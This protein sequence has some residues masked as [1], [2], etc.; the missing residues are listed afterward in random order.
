[1]SRMPIFLLLG[2][3][4][5]SSNAPSAEPSVDA[6]MDS[7]IDAGVD[8]G[9]D[10]GADSGVDAGVDAG[11]SQRR[12]FVTDTIQ[13]AD[14]G[15]VSGADALC[16][17]QAAAA[18]LEGQFKAWL[19]TI[20]SPVADRL[21]HS[22]VPYVL[23][24][25]TLIANDWADLVDGSIL[26][27]IRLDASGLP[28]GGD[29]WTGTL[30]NGLAYTNGDCVGYTSSSGGIGLCGDTGATNGGWTASATPE[31]SLALRLYCVED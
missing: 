21:T 31:C 22:S 30:A 14:F 29:V 17:S 23:V 28:H 25:G 7:G 9:I 18:G 24:D 2:S 1:M 11:V 19:S 6:G 26:S 13:S 15:G 3:V 20:A 27:P 5:C 4:A 8:A 12:V 16:A 10:A